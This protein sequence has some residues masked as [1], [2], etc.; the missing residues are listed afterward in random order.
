MERM[1]SNA[2]YIRESIVGCSSKWV[3]DVLK[4]NKQQNPKRLK[5]SEK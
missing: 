1:K 3:I 5:L 2:I 4:G